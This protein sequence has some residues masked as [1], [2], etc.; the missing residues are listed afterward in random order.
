MSLAKL[1]LNSWR[2]LK[3]LPKDNLDFERRHP[4]QSRGTVALPFLV[5]YLT[6]ALAI[7]PPRVTLALTVYG[8]AS[9]VAMPVC[10]PP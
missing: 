7:A 2:G 9:F 1:T 10:W 4:H 8:I 5:L 3:D 6:R